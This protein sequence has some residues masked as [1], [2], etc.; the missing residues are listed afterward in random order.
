[1]AAITDAL[2]YC[3]GKSRPAGA[4]FGLPRLSARAISAATVLE[5]GT[6]RAEPPL[7]PA[8]AGMLTQGP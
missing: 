7:T 1:M 2:A 4:R 8:G 6:V 3:S 5:A